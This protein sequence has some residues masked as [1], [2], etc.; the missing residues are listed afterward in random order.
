MPAERTTTTEQ[1][2]L[3]EPPEQAE[4]GRPPLVMVDLSKRQT[5]ER[6]KR[7]RRGRGSLLKRIEEI[8]EALIQA[9]TVK[10]GAQPVVIV[11]REKPSMIWPFATDDTEDEDD[12]DEDDEDED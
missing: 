9:G 6:I 5:S 8:V 2:E 3:G 1:R 7:L 4:T 12:E 10:A 11:V